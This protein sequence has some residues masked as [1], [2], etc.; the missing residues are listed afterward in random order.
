MA[1]NNKVLPQAVEIERCVLGAL[2]INK[3]AFD[4]VSDRLRPESF[5][6][7]KHQIIFGVMQNMVLQ[8]K[9]VDMLTLT[10]EL[11]NTN[12]LDRVGGAVYIADLCNKVASSANIE[13]HSRII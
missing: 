9:P 13:Y 8:N 1:E 12:K 2:M 10:D 3:E 6:D 7:P 11:L 5:Y 4:I